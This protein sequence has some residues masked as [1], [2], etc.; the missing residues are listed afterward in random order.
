M[1]LASVLFPDYRRKVLALLLLHPESS[2]H[3][4]EIARL[5]ETQSGTLSRELVKLVAAGLAV[6]TRVGNQQHYRANR[7]CP[8]FEELASIL[9][10]TS[11]LTDILA[12]ALSPIADR[13]SAAFVFG[14]MA[15][16]KAS[17]GSD[18]DL[19][20][21]GTVTFREVVA[22]LYPCQETLGREI[23]PK[24]YQR[25]EWQR[26]LAEGGAFIT[27]LLEKPKVF[28]IGDASYLSQGRTDDPG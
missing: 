23:N 1:S 20:I 6:K 28:V 24:V 26:L 4:R 9:R 5:T 18:I 21:L 7:E 12:E 19:M 13:I 3:Q 14:S 27:D 17:A 2:Y 22:S 25:E 8:I 15:S 16:G 10:K 11:G